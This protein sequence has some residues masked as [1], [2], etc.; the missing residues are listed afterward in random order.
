MFW[1]LVHDITAKTKAC[2]LLDPTLR[3]RPQLQRCHVLEVPSQVKSESFAPFPVDWRLV[4]EEGFWGQRLCQKNNQKWYGCLKQ[5]R[6]R[7]IGWKTRMLEKVQR[8]PKESVGGQESGVPAW[9]LGGQG[10]TGWARLLCWKVDIEV[11]SPLQI[12]EGLFIN[13]CPMIPYISL[14]CLTWPDLQCFWCLGRYTCFRNWQCCCGHFL[15][16]SED[17]H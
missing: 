10:R 6:K 17:C 13:I 8:L 12:H 15:V 11:G 2:F 9:A 3:L 5:K 7:Q 1:C 14:L 4:W 16:F